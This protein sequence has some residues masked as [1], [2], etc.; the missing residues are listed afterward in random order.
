MLGETGPLD[1]A[2]VNRLDDLDWR[3]TYAGRTTQISTRGSG[4]PD[5]AC[6]RSRCLQSH[7]TAPLSLARGLLSAMSRPP[8]ASIRRSVLPPRRR[9]FR[10][11]PARL[12]QAGASLFT[13]SSGKPLPSGIPGFYTV[14]GFYDVLLPS[15]P[16]A[17]EKIA[18]ES[19]VLG[20]SPEVRW[21]PN[22][23]Q[24]EHDAITRPA[25]PQT[26]RRQ[27]ERS[28]DHATRQS[29]TPTWRSSNRM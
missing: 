24:L 19:W 26:Q 28:V 5:G 17:A 29:Q 1:P 2:L 15:S 14:K 13:R 11:A 12:G 4:S 10:P 7:S 22:V 20:D 27:L 23:G 9:R 3:N 25:N 18:S 21:L 8:I 6:S 16:K